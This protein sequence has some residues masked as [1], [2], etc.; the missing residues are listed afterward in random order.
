MCC[1][2]QRAGRRSDAG[3]PSEP[4]AGPG[5]VPG[6]LVAR[7]GR[8]DGRAAGR[9][10]ALRDRWDSLLALVSWS[11]G[12]RRRGPG[13]T[14][15]PWS[16]ELDRGPRRSMPTG[17]RRH[18][19]IAARGQGAGMGRGV[20]GRP[21]RRHPAD[22]AR[23]RRPEEIEEERRL[24]YVGVTRARMPLALVLG[25]VADPR[26]PADPQPPRFLTGIAPRRR[27]ESGPGPRASVP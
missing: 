9:P 4:G 17:G 25:A 6:A 24:F 3:Q 20:P 26:W 13:A 2:P 15:R 19:R 21:H 5:L 14:C 12:T 23:G 11:R 1:A 18:P 22:P 27:R 7:P 10:G 16:A 8:P